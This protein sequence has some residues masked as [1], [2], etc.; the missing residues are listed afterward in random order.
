MDISPF[1]D[2]PPDHRRR[3]HPILSDSTCREIALSAPPGHRRIQ[4]TE[5]VTAR[6]PRS[7]DPGRVESRPCFVLTQRLAEGAVSRRPP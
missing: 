4:E 7:A 1:V 5:S 3:E 2:P 6:R